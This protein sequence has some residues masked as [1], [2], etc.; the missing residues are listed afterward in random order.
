MY[1]PYPQVFT[2]LILSYSGKD[3]SPPVPILLSNHLSSVER[4]VAIIDWAEEVVEYLSLILIIATSFS[5]ELPFLVIT[6][7]E[8][9][10]VLLYFLCQVLFQSHLGLPTQLTFVSILFLGD[11]P[12]LASAIFLFSLTSKLLLSHASLLSSLPD[13]YICI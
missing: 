3:F 4:E 7:L 9:L 1:I 2:N 12:I 6:L 5:S 11:F 13:T 8:A 10:P